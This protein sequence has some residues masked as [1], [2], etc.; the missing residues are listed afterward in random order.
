M[1]ARPKPTK[2]R[3]APRSR[4]HDSLTVSISKG[5]ADNSDNDSSRRSKVYY[6]G[7][8][9]PSSPHT[10]SARTSSHIAPQSEEGVPDVG[11]DKEYAHE[12]Q[13]R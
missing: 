6:T 1:G 4:L 2:S 3:E 13:N 9:S 12:R 5:R 10:I 11:P 7:C 8:V